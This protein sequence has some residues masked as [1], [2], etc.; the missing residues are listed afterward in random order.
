M[1]NTAVFE[2]RAAKL[3]KDIEDQTEK[4]LAARPSQILRGCGYH[5]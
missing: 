2:S 5:A 3:N 4:L 1:G